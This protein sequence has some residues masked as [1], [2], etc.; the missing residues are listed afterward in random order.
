MVWVR[1][2]IVFAVVLAIA[3][4]AHDRWLA[5]RLAGVLA[6]VDADRERNFE[7][8]EPMDWRLRI[9]DLH[10]DLCLALIRP[11][12][13]RLLPATGRLSLPAGLRARPEAGGCRRLSGN[14]VLLTEGR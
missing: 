11:E 6:V 8:G 4:A 13:F 14:A 7:D 2:G 5:H 1:R 12:T 9:G 10:P 3:V